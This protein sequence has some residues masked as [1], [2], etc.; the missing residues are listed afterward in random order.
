M[1]SLLS[2]EKREV[3][4]VQL[5]ILPTYQ[6]ESTYLNFPDIFFWLGSQIT[7]SNTISD[8]SNTVAYRKGIKGN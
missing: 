6:M 5:T 7:N 8:D 1:I 2:A 3:V 4:A